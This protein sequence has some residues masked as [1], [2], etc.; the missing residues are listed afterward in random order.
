MVFAIISKFVNDKRLSGG[1]DWLTLIKYG[2]L[3]KI[4]FDNPLFWDV[5]IAFKEK[6]CRPGERITKFLN[7]YSPVFVITVEF[8]Y[9]NPYDNK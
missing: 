6:K 4:L 1:V 2:S 5:S 9:N 3:I 8:P 7:K